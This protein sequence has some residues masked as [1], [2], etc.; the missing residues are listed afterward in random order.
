MIVSTHL[1]LYSGQLPRYHQATLALRNLNPFAHWALSLSLQPY[2]QPLEQQERESSPRRR[3]LDSLT[4]SSEFL[5][6]LEFIVAP[7]KKIL[8]SHDRPLEGKLTQVAGLGA[9]LQLSNTDETDTVWIRRF[10]TRTTFFESLVER[11]PW[12]L[13]ELIIEND[14]ADFR[15]LSINCMVNNKEA[16]QALGHRWDNWAKAVQEGALV[17][18]KFAWKALEV[19]KAGQFTPLFSLHR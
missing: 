6:T 13:S 2:P 9:R 10:P 18:Q 14:L 15:N 8:Q 3:S 1:Y 17:D 11:S 4:T 7:I 19:A 16:A 12:E 5:S